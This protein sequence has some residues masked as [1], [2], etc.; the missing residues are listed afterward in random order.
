MKKNSLDLNSIIYLKDFE[1]HS[2][3]LDSLKMR[4]CTSEL[5][6]IVEFG[7]PEDKEESFERVWSILKHLQ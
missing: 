6:M 5:V 3:A 1:K 7:I 2:K 4:Y